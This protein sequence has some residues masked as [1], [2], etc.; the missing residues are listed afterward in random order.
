L[1]NGDSGRNDVGANPAADAVQ[2][3]YFADF[4]NQRFTSV[5][6]ADNAICS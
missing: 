5:S 4:A 3:P 1:K 6:V 2:T